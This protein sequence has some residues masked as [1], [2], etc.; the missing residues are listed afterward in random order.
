MFFDWEARKAA[1]N[2]KKHGVSFSEA[3][4]VFGDDFSSCVA[5]PDNSHGEARFLMFGTTLAGVVLVVSFTEDSDTI[6]IIS[7]RRM[8]AAE[9]KAYER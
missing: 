2:L 9:R 5:D 4:E 7:A 6:R 1:A 8:T 3:T